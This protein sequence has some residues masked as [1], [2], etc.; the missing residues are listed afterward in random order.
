MLGNVSPLHR[1]SISGLAARLLRYQRLASPNVPLRPGGSLGTILVYPMET[2]DKQAVLLSVLARDTIELAPGKVERRGPDEN[3]SRGRLLLYVVRRL[4]TRI[5]A[6]EQP[7][8]IRSHSAQTRPLTDVI[9]PGECQPNP[10][11]GMLS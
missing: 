5:R 4:W 2:S 3:T 1:L 6:G 11:R 10:G 8:F 7:A 9:R